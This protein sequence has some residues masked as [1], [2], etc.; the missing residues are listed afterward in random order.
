MYSR[1]INGA[2][3]VL[4]CFILQ[5]CA[6]FHAPQ[7]SECDN[8][9]D[10]HTLSLDYLNN[11]VDV[12]ENQALTRMDKV[13]QVGGKL[14]DEKIYTK[15]I[16]QLL[17]SCGNEGKLNSNN[18]SAHTSFENIEE[19]L[20]SSY[21]LGRTLERK[22]KVLPPN[23]TQEDLSDLLKVTI[24][25][26]FRL[27]YGN[28]NCDLTQCKLLEKS[29]R[30]IN[31]WLSQRVDIAGEVNDYI[32]GA[33]NEVK[34]KAFYYLTKGMHPS[35]FKAQKISAPYNYNKQDTA[36]NYVENK[37]KIRALNRLE[38]RLSS[39]SGVDLPYVREFISKG[40][41]ENILEGD[42]VA[43]QAP[44]ES[45][46]CGL[47]EGWVIPIILLANSSTLYSEKYS[48]GIS[49]NSSPLSL[50]QAN[51][52]YIRSDFDAAYEKYV[53][54]KGKGDSFA[55][56]MAADMMYL[57]LIHDRVY[58][59][60]A[61]TT[62]KGEMDKQKKHWFSKYLFGKFLF[63][64]FGTPLKNK[65]LGSKYLLELLPRLETLGSKR[66]DNLEY[67]IA[68]YAY[69]W[70]SINIKK[71]KSDL[72]SEYL[73]SASRVYPAAALLYMNCIN[74][75]V[76]CSGSE[77]KAVINYAEK[78]LDHAYK[79]VPD[80]ENFL[81]NLYRSRG[82]EL[83]KYID[84]YRDSSKSGH[85]YGTLH[86]SDAIK[87]DWVLNKDCLSLKKYYLELDAERVIDPGVYSGVAANIINKIKEN[88]T[89]IGDILSTHCK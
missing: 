37:A 19:L 73:L 56:A 40:N 7:Y 89:T 23:P 26:K 72:I 70:I 35:F 53:L 71:E 69:A 66:G 74:T 11:I 16:S 24:K 22:D 78:D 67:Y 77:T 84:L 55:A 8:A 52:L 34:D 42:E 49:S 28:G 12:V 27:L 62:V 17:Y 4:L 14:S 10:Y 68:R 63:Y 20:D 32:G 79:D 60:D 50:N 9:L 54:L 80:I 75:G 36:N 48:E 64:G 18:I 82:F 43:C 31:E 46:R 41:F 86:F 38:H 15:K 51:E 76:Y 57:G 39:E 88:V 85:A 44:S 30:V 33:E 59:N 87:D 47:Y 13:Y 58:Y 61:F 2:F 45:E 83:D 25:E 6:S 1:L 3:F 65:E 5:S 29:R 21:T 81:A